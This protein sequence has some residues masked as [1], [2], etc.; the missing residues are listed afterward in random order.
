[1]ALFSSTGPVSQQTNT[2]SFAAKF[3][4]MAPARPASTNYTASA[5]AVKDPLRP[6]SV[7]SLPARPLPLA[8]SK[9]TNPPTVPHSSHPLSV[10]HPV[11][12]PPPAPAPKP[13]PAPIQSQSSG[14]RTFTTTIHKGE[15]GIGLD[16][17][18]NK[19]GLAVVLKLKV[20]PAGIPNPAS[21]CTVPLVAGDIITAVNGVQCGL[22]SEAVRLIR[23]CESQ[24]VVT[25]LRS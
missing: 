21:T 6:A 9:L 23:A 10:S 18:K 16:L 2:H 22:F 7:S 1:M 14:A 8:P 17:G 4:S 25:I 12:R 19:D 11:T 5:S 20:M 15:H 13:T 24:V 3:Q